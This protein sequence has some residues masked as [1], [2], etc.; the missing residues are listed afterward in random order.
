MIRIIIILMAA[1]SWY[2]AGAV[3]S[4]QLMLYAICLVVFMLVMHIITMIHSRNTTFAFDAEYTNV[5]KQNGCPVKINVRNNSGIPITRIRLDIEAAYGFYSG[6][7]KNKQALRQQVYGSC[8]RK[9]DSIRFTVAMPYTGPAH[10]HIKRAY[11]YDYTGAVKTKLK[12][13][14]IY[15]NIAV[16]PVLHDGSSRIE[17]FAAD[18][19]SAKELYINKAGNA[20]DDVRQIREYQTGDSY[21]HIHWNLTARTGSLMVR[22]FSQETDMEINIVPEV[23]I[24]AINDYEKMGSF[25]DKLAD[26]TMWLVK[27]N[28][29]INMLWYDYEYDDFLKHPV[30]SRESCYD[31]LYELFLYHEKCRTNNKLSVMNK[32]LPY[33]YK[34]G[35][36]ICINTQ[37]EVFISN[38]YKKCN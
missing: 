35:N 24:D 5:I 25:Y 15:M 37:V 2:V 7:G 36:L 26:E 33:I 9:K 8:R 11:L 17:A 19:D 13:D 18:S 3:H 16:L 23:M 28:N 34:E 31:A 14:N 27:D 12:L 4:F 6:A 29:I 20:V 1:V 38:N 22:E 10:I 30:S 21:R 32:E